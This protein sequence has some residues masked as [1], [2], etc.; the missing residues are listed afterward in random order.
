MDGIDMNGPK[1]CIS[2]VTAQGTDIVILSTHIEI[3]YNN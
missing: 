3:L 2:Y 1:T